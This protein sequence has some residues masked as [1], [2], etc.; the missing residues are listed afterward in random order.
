MVR[1]Q[2]LFKVD[3]QL[4]T[5]SVYQLASI[6]VASPIPQVR[7]LVHREFLLPPPSS[8]SPNIPSSGSIEHPVSITPLLLTSTDIRTPKVT[9]L[10]SNPHV[11]LAWWVEGTQEQFRITGTASVLS[12]NEN[13]ELHQSFKYN[14]KHAHRG[15]GL[16]IWSDDR[17]GKSIDWEEKRLEVFKKMSAHMKASWCRPVPGS[18][19][20]SHEEAKKWPEKLTEPNPDDD[21]EKY[22]EDKK[23]WET[24]LHNFALVLIDP[25]EVDYVELG[26]MPNRRTRFWRQEDG[27]WGEEPLVP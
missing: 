12:G 19:I 23:N 11:S 26:V 22:E 13:W 18:K 3:T 5:G 6:D 9:Q 17:E 27:H 14:V 20:K 8:P 1:I 16:G 7:T 10:I 25:E 21:K 4:T 24:A 15:S 2:L